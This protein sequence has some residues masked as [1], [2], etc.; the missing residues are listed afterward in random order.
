MSG[1]R[2]KFRVRV[3]DSGVRGLLKGGE[4]M[5]HRKNRI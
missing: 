2:G 1:L 3:Q 5:S 4:P